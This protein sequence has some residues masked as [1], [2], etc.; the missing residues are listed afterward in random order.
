MLILSINPESY[1]H[2]LI[3]FVSTGCSVSVAL[4]RGDRMSFRY[5]PKDK[6]YLVLFI[7]FLITVVLSLFLMYK[8]K[9]SSYTILILSLTFLL[10]VGLLI[11]GIGIKRKQ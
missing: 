11:R 3:F 1:I 6:T 5:F 8:D 10:L 9:N 2:R 7:L 4:Y